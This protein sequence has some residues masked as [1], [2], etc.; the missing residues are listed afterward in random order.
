MLARKMDRLQ[1][2]VFPVT[3]GLPAKSMFEIIGGTNKMNIELQDWEMDLGA[4]NYWELVALAS[5]VKRFSPKVIF[6][7]GTG[8]GRSTLQMANNTPEDT[9]IHTL[10]ISDEHPVGL[11]IKD[12]PQMEKI[13]RIKA[14]SQEFDYTPFHEKVDFVLVDGAHDYGNVMAD[15]EKAFD[16]VSKK[17]HIIWDDFSPAWSGVVKALKEI[18]Q[19]RE[20]FRIPGTSYVIY[21][22]P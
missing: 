20:V 14:S 10:D 18:R 19:S 4:G 21:T 22:Q 11:I 12:K 2:M 9:V 5:F 8:H 15:S 6:E 3:S 17:G 7:I 13:R 1:R 16:M